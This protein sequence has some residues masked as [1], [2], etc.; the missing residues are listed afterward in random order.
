MAQD[1][2]EADGVIVNGELRP[3]SLVAFRQAMK[4]FSNEAR[5]VISVKVLRARR[6][7]QQNRFYH[8]VVIPLFAEH[9]GYQFD[10][11]KDALALKLLP[12]EVTDPTTGEVHVVP[13]H[14]SELT[15]KEFNALIERAQQLGA[16]MGLYIPDPNEGERISA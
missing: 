8:G 2:Y 6:S 15:T 14:T 13:G 1:S 10:D 11:M 3:V 5:V 7:N 4:R 9:C 12:K 16:E